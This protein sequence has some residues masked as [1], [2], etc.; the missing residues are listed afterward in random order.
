MQTFVCLF[1]YLYLYDFSIKSNDRA[2]RILNG[3][4]QI[5]CMSCT[6]PT[7][8]QPI[9]PYFYHL[10]ATMALRSPSDFDKLICLRARICTPSELTV[11]KLPKK[12]KTFAKYACHW[13]WLLLVVI[14]ASIMTNFQPFC[15]Q[16]KRQ[17]SICM[18]R[19]FDI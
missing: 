13:T 12:C 17:Y 15:L 16:K 4:K 9:N 6:Y 7:R 3:I 19:G 10:N 1:V 11:A 8:H 14:S 18:M 5:F 2:S